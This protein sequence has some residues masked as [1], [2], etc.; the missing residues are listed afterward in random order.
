MT[1]YRETFYDRHT[2]PYQLKI[3][4]DQHSRHTFGCTCAVYLFRRMVKSSRKKKS[5][6]RKL[7]T[8]SGFV[9]LIRMLLATSQ[10]K[11][12]TDA[13]VSISILMSTN[14]INLQWHKY[15]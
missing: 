11:T 5:G 9:L 4:Q 12:F 13:A 2:A 7:F 15:I 6:S 3:L 1:M 8:P 10:R 14:T